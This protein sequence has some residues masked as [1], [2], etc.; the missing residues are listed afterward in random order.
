MCRFIAYK[1]E[2]LSLD[3]LL[4]KPK[5]SLIKQSIAARELEE[6]LN[7][8]GFGIGWYNKAFDPAP[9]IFVSMTPAWSNR[10]LKNLAPRIQS[11][12]I[13]AHV[14]AASVGDINEANCHPFYYGAW[15][16][17]HNGSIEQFA[18]IKREVRRALSDEVYNWVKGQTDSEHLF[19]MILDHFSDDEL[20]QARPESIMAAIEQ[21]LRFIENLQQE[22]KLPRENYVNSCLTNGKFMVAT[23][24]CSKPDEEPLSL[25]YSV[26]TRY[27][28]EGGVCRIDKSGT[29]KKAALIV[30]EPLTD[31]ANDW[32][33][34]PNNHFIVIDEALNVSFFPIKV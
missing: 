7:G 19:G 8:D 9:A 28:C 12:C 34:V 32:V 25:Y 20:V 23:R 2:A 1:G 4:F 29:G 21:S 22:H 26:G 31:L 17:M 11:D 24:Y 30:S 18:A 3:D 10:N 33:K 16:F 13:F 14:R 5:Y 15:M 6:P 27:E